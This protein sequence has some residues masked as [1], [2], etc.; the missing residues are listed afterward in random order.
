MGL[1]TETSVMVNVGVAQVGG[2]VHLGARNPTASSLDFTL[3][4]G[5]GGTQLLT[6]EG[7][8]RSD[9]VAPILRYTAMIFRSAHARIRRDGRL[10]FSGELDVVHV[11]REQILPSWNSANNS[12]SYTDPKTSRSA[13]TVTFVLA[14]PRAQFLA[15]YLEKHSD[16]ILSATIDAHSFP[17]LPGIILDSDWP[18]VA[19]DEH[20]EPVNPTVNLRDYSGWTC[21]G[22]AIT[23]TAA[24][25]PAQTF[26]L[27]YSGPRRYNAPTDGPVTILLHLKLAS[28]PATSPPAR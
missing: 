23:K 3:V 5:G 4:P 15:P 6:P 12:P 9:V 19:E 26:G 7:T 16:I 27:D 17:D 28:A 24:L 22:K 18:A 25:Q 10:E 20:C 2:S 8:L 11:T 14:S 1:Q 21:D 13:R